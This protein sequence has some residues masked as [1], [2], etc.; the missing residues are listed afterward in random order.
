LKGDAAVDTTKLV[1]FGARD[2][3]P[4]IG[5][6]TAKDPILFAGDGPNLYVYVLNDPVNFVDSNGKGPTANALCSEAKKRG[7]SISQ[8]TCEAIADNISFS[9]ALELKKSASNKND[10]E[11]GKKACKILR[12][13]IRK[14]K[15]HCSK[16]VNEDLDRC[17]SKLLSDCQ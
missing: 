16:Q 2:Y 13:A 15:K 17:A 11:A 4:H 6:W 7:C 9:Q 8:E 1:R 12:D 14:T 5:R 10:P 3:D